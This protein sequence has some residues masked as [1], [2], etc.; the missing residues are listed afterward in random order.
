MFTIWFIDDDENFM[1]TVKECLKISKDKDYGVFDGR[2]AIHFKDPHIDGQGIID[3]ITYQSHSIADI[4]DLIFLDLRYPVDKKNNVIDVMSLSGIK[5]LKAIAQNEIFNS[6][7]V[8]IFSE[9]PLDE[10]AKENIKKMLN[11]SERKQLFI[12]KHKMKLSSNDIEINKLKYYLSKNCN[13]LQK[14]IDSLH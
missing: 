1:D 7:N 5:I 9:V 6:T 3:T 11:F 13:S 4:P 12:D 14:I 10:T 8:C 2:I